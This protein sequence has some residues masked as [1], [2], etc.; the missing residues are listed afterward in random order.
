MVFTAL[1]FASF[2]FTPQTLPSVS[3]EFRD[4]VGFLQNIVLLSSAD[5]PPCW[6][7]ELLSLTQMG[8]SG[9]TAARTAATAPSSGA[10]RRSSAPP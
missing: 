8:K 10:A 3:Q 4:T 9:P 6:K 2:A 1:Q 5:R 7:S